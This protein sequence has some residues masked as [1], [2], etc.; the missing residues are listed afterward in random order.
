MPLPISTTEGSK[1]RLARFA[2]ALVY[3]LSSLA[4]PFSEPLLGN[5]GQSTARSR[6]RIGC[7][8][9]QGLDASGNCCC[10][11]RQTRLCCVAK[12][13]P[14]SNAD[15]NSRSCFPKLP[16]SSMPSAVAALSACSCGVDATLQAGSGDPR[17]IQPTLRRAADFVVCRAL[18]FVTL[19]VP[20]VFHSPADPVPRCWL[21]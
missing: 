16:G 10:V 18:D 11:V 21:S 3:S 2:V 14:A 15:Q 9:F 13:P 5:T 19:R 8:C 7:L 1:L 12:Q 20:S 17:M 6:H 4:L